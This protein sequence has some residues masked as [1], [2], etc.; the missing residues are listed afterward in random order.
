MLS[1]AQ[2]EQTVQGIEQA[3]R[4]LLKQRLPHLVSL[5]S[6]EEVTARRGPNSTEASY[7]ARDLVLSPAS[8]LHDMVVLSIVRELQSRFPTV[9]LECR[10]PI[11]YSIHDPQL[12]HARPMK[13]M[14]V[15]VHRER[16]SVTWWEAVGK[17]AKGL[18]IVVVSAWL[19][20]WLMSAGSG[21]GGGDGPPPPPFSYD[22]VVEP[23]YSF[24]T[25]VPALSSPVP[26]PPHP[27]KPGSRGVV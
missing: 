20:M 24:Q 3:L 9:W 10:F 23:D 1:V 18:A 26:S 27:H 11:Y 14:A 7:A 13:T 16:A 17:P 2:F 8:L 21:H 22:D 19:I 4:E 25:G 6:S 12:G 5:E 15:R